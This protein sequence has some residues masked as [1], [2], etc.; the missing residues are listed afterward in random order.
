M[1]TQDKAALWTDSRYWTQAERELDCSWELQRTSQCGQHG[2][3]PRPFPSP[4]LGLLWAQRGLGHRAN[5]LCPAASIES[6]AM[7]ILKVVPSEGNVSLDPFL[8]SIGRTGCSGGHPARGRAACGFRFTRSQNLWAALP[9]DTWNSYSRALQ[10]SGRTLLPLETNLVDQAWGD[11]RP[12]PSSSEI[13]SLP[14]EFT[15]LNPTSRSCWVGTQHP[16]PPQA[17]PAVGPALGCDHWPDWQGAAG[18]RRWLGS[19]SRWSSTCSTPRLCCCQGWRRQPVSTHRA[20]V[21]SWQG[22]WARTLGLGGQWSL[23]C[24]FLAGLFNLRGDDIPYNPVFYSYT[25][26]TNTTIRWATHPC[27]HGAWRGLTTHL[28]PPFPS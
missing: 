14:A 18:R 1:V 25:L 20:V 10:G 5:Q 15:G 4:C 8:F 22:P 27:G 9:P 11:Q 16:Q 17:G 12:P 23:R 21:G 6:I 13:Y 2:G 28:L 3:L 26:L 19:D 7:W 24:S